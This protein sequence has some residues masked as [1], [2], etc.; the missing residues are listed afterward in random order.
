MTDKPRNTIQ[1]VAQALLNSDIEQGHANADSPWGRYEVLARV[2][3][4]CM[5]ARGFVSES[6]LKAILEGRA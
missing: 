5:H 6:S 1:A 3:I 4:T 2:A